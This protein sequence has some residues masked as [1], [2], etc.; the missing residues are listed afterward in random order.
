M[1]RT[2]TT[3]LP[4]NEQ[5]SNKTPIIILVITNILFA[6]LAIYFFTQKNAKESEVQTLTQN[7]DSKSAEVAAKTK[8]LEDLNV[9]LNRIRTE[10]EQL[11]LQNDSLDNQISQLNSYISEIKSQGKIDSKKRKELEALV[12]QLREEITVKDKEIAVL[13]TQNDSLSTNLT[14]VSAEK[15]RLGD[16]LTTKLKE[17]EYASI[18]K[19]DDI[20]V[21]ALKENGKELDK[22]EYK[23]KQIDRIKISFKIADNKAAKKNTKTFYVRLVTPTG[24]PFSDLNNG[25]GT[26]ATADGE[27]IL[28]TFSQSL[29]FDNT[30]QVVT[31]TMPK[32]FNYL[33]GTYKVEVFAEGY[34]IGDG[35][36][37]VK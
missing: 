27:D 16:S 17:L 12:T 10:R 22:E 33:P 28:Y 32:G 7:V 23:A 29:A 21:T 8:E 20:K 36:F 14:S 24:A 30:R 9:E 13:K 34:K 25:G 26:I 4:E 2:T 1:R 31:T 18:L 11:G 19:A 3:E 37:K 15:G 5:K 6:A 35:S